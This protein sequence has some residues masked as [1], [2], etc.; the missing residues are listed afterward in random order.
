VEIDPRSASVGGSWQ[1]GNFAGIQHAWDMPMIKLV[2]SF[3][4][5]GC[6]LVDVGASTGSFSLLPAIVEDARV[7]AF[8]P[9]PV[10]FASLLANI[11]I[12]GLARSISA[13]NLALYSE[14]SVL[15]LKIPPL[16]SQHGLAC[17]GQPIRFSGGGTKTVE[18]L[19]LDNIIMQRIHVLKIDTE[20]CE[21]HVLKGGERTILK[22]KPVILCEYNEINC[23]QFGYD[24]TDIKV[25]LESWGARTKQVGDED[26]LAWWE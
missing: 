12:N 21:W 5:P 19:A 20:G 16:M 23:R 18:A 14:D 7:S 17:L 15:I 22:D 3:M 6:H 13:Y 25:L 11:K 9:N 4:F 1:G 2:H 8:E 26:L 10:A 24:H